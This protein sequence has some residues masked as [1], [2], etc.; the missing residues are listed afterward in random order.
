MPSSILRVTG[1]KA[2]AGGNFLVATLP[3]DVGQYIVTAK[4]D[5]LSGFD[6]QACVSRLVV[7]SQEDFAWNHLAGP[8]NPGDRE[9]FCLIG[10]AEVTIPTPAK[11]FVSLGSHRAILDN[12]VI[13]AILVTDLSIVEVPGDRIPPDA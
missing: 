10:G 1:S 12:I 8:G 2:V 6:G 13:S 7:G 11:L 5:V 3:L 9:A 4:A